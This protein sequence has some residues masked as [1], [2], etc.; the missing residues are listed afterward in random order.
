LTSYQ[1]DDIS[2]GTPIETPW[3]FEQ[4]ESRACANYQITIY[5]CEAEIAPNRKTVDVHKCATITFSARSGSSI[6]EGAEGQR[7]RVV[8][9]D[10]KMSMLG[11]GK[12]DFATYV[13]GRLASRMDVKVKLGSD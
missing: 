5:E 11:M 3:A 13:D 6:R 1:G 8:R 2:Q 7:Y 10:V 4:P 12:L 9:F